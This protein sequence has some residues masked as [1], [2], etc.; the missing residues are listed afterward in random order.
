MSHNCPV[1]GKAGLPD[2]KTT[3]VVCPQCDSDLKPYFLINKIRKSKN[4]YL[5]IISTVVI[6]LFILSGS[7]YYQ[8]SS[9]KNKI[10]RKNETKIVFLQN[11]INELQDS[12]QNVI[13]KIVTEQP[14]REIFINY[15]VKKDD[16]P[17]KIA[18]F[19][20]NDWKMYKQIEKDNN[21]Q[22]P[23]TLKVGQILKIKIKQE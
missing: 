18:E 6:F 7:I 9:E 8:L 20:Y 19:F 15:K 22:Q 2:F 3:H 13:G 4:K 14:M 16:Y 17:S 21:L 1:D 12:I 23:Y 5:V 11:S 10:Q